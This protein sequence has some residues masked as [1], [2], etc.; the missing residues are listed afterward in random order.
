MSTPG[1]MTFHRFGRTY[2]LE[3]ADAA[4]LAHALELD[5]AH[6]VA[7][8]V[9]I[10]SLRGDPIFFN[11]VDIDNN[12]RIRI[13]ELK[14]AIQWLL[15][16]L[17]D[18]TGIAQRSDVL[19]INAINTHTADGTKIHTAIVKILNTL[20]QPNDTQISL[21]QIR[22]IKS[23]IEAMPVSE[24]GV[25]LPQA[26]Q[27]ETVRQFITD[28]IATTGGTHH[29]SGQ[30]GISTAEINQFLTQMNACLDWYDRGGG[31]DPGLYPLGN[32]TAAAFDLLTSY[33]DRLDQYFAQCRGVAFDP[34]LADHMPP[35]DSDVAKI[36]VADPNA[37]T[38][39]V[40][41]APL[42][43]ADPDGKLDFQKPIN[44][45]ERG[46]LEQL[47]SSVLAPVLGQEVSQLTE[48]Q[49]QSVIEHF[50]AYESWMRAKP[51]DAV[52][53]LGLDKLRDYRQGDYA[54]T[55]RQ[56][57]EQGRETALQMDSVRLVEQLMLYQAYLLDLANNF[58]SFPHLYNPDRRAM[59]EAGALIM[60]GRRFDLAVKTE[61]RAEHAKSTSSS[62]MCVLY[63]QI[64]RHDS[65]VSAEMAVPVT[66]GGKGNLAVGKRGIFIDVDGREWDARVV[67]IVENPISFSEAMVAPF[68][69]MGRLVS[70]KFEQMTGSAEKQLD[71]ATQ[72]TMT[73][74][75]TAG[76]QPQAAA[77]NRGLMAGGLLAGGGLA[78]AALGSAVAYITK[79][80]AGLS[81][82]AIIGGLGGAVLA[83]LLPTAIQAIVKLRHRDLSAILEGS[84]W[85][86]NTRMRLTHAQSR[87]FTQRPAYP[88][89]AKGVHNT[90]WYITLLVLLIVL[91]LG[92]M[93]A[94]SQIK[95]YRQRQNDTAKST[96]THIEDNL[97]DDFQ[98]VSPPTTE[99][100]KTLTP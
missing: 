30:N 9:P 72:Q 4:D 89:S 38:E 54:D 27:D 15:T 82:W 58:V 95:Q 59:F 34:R 49:W 80:L 100:P 31:N 41:L 66:A 79:T 21:G 87:Q 52:A 84:G 18:S 88:P 46:G 55:V 94:N 86:I 98:S 28:V 6:W 69:R 57:I 67:Q 76:Q 56:L 83:V 26:T 61:N 17:S 20:D 74:V 78:F 40:R 62:A 60:D 63:V 36:D 99:P 10:A 45:L 91:G 29:P 50:A 64:E 48:A 81:I 85:A 44:P 93:F 22:S 8:S 39:F 2:Q 73:Q 11:L 96:Q 33:R 25:V 47:R 19:L 14:L 35:T 53:A 1:A 16:Q 43:Q 65:P 90:R 42:A 32:D 24:A 71:T 12:G 5:E 97:T 23:R 92:A 68:K 70:G 37:I 7:T 51:A 13:S 3:L 75:Q 77:Q